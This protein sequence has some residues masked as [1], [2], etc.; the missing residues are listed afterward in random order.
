MIWVRI[1]LSSQYILPI[2]MPFDHLLDLDS[3]CISIQ[4]ELAEITAVRAF[5]S[6]P[7]TFPLLTPSN[8]TAHLPG[9]RHVRL[10]RLEP[11]LRTLR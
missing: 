6:F 8:K 10:L 1:Y 9:P 5:P 4:R 7:L 11:A 2:L 3:F